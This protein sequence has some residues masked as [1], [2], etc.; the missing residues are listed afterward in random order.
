MYGRILI[1]TLKESTEPSKLKEFAN[2][3]VNNPAYDT[4]VSRLKELPGFIFKIHTV[5]DTVSEHKILSQVIF[6]NEQNFFEYA[7][8]AENISVWEIIKDYAENSGLKFEFIDGEFTAE[9]LI[10]HYISKS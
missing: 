3:I 6:D 4:I 5:L 2:D 8:A 9:T 1:L 10:Q 7:N